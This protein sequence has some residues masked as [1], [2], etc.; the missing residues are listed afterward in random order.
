MRFKAQKACFGKM[1]NLCRLVGHFL[2]LLAF[3][4]RVCETHV[5]RPQNGEIEADVLDSGAEGGLYLHATFGAILL[6]RRRLSDSFGCLGQNG[7]F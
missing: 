1:A 7:H 4:G 5:S 2:A 3:Y 6:T